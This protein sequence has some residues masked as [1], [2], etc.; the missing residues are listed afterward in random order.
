[1]SIDRLSPLP[2][3]LLECSVVDGSG[4]A[5]TFEE[6]TRSQPTLL[7]FV[8]HFG[9]IGCSENIAL[10]APRF[11]E[12]HTLGVRNVIIGCGAPNFIQGF[13]ER[14]RLFGQPVEVFT[15]PSLTAHQAA[16]LNYGSWGGFGP[17]ALY[18]MAR[19]YVSGQVSGPIEGDIKQQAGAIFVDGEGQVQLYH[20]A[21]SLGDHVNT[22]QLVEAAM[23]MR[24]DSHPELV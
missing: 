2:T 5:S 9:C 19:A 6:M 18:E 12:L 13:K 21:D 11:G 20:R 22:L 24:I 7:L 23:A 1:M 3:A 16:E 17:K 14:N 15:D 10:V 4:Q 8:R